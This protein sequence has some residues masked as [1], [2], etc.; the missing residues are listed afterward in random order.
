MVLVTGG[1]GF[2]GQ[3]LIRQL[4]SIG[5]PVRTLLR[6]SI[7]SPRLP[8][9]VSVE[10]AVC[11]LKDERGLM[12]A[13]K[14]VDVVIHLASA[15][16]LGSRADLMGVDVEGTEAI[17]NVAEKAKVD[18][19]FY[20]S[21]LGADKSSAFPVLKAKA[22]A[23]SHI[24]NSG[25]NYT[26]FRSSVIF[27]KEDHFTTSF[28]HLLKKVP[29]YFLLPGNGDVLLQPIWI[30]DLVACLTLAMETNN[31][32]KQI[33]SIGG[34]EY[35]S[36]RGIIEIIMNNLGIN[37]KFITI[38]PAYLRM[39][40]FLFEQILPRYVI[41]LYWLDYLAS[42][43]MCSLDVLPR[44]FGLMPARFKQKLNYLNP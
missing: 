39:F 37:R 10:V 5:K 21:H 2:I 8:R 11:S 23:E 14:D 17:T 25:I 20:I 31:L 36:F 26:I 24:I 3:V 32:N 1:T 29:G 35:I 28:T 33:C 43:R 6:P 42:D 4:V 7:A 13:M 41:S 27:G 18:R 16:Q 19:F 12:A 34:S 15:E 30:E 40:S 9:G 38:Y 22:I 44:L